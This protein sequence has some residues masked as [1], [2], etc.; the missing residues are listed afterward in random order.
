MQ[1][2]TNLVII[3]G[4][5]GA[6][7]D[8]IIE[9]LIKQGLPIE[10]AITTVTRD[11][12]EGES[13]GNPYYFIDDATFTERIA[14]DAFAEW[15]EVYGVKRGLSKEELERL[16]KQKDRIGVIKVDWQGVQTIKKIV[17]DVL[18]ILVATE[19]IDDMVERGIKRGKD[20]KEAILSRVDFS[21]EWLTHRDIYDY[22]VMNA[23]GKLDQ[24]I[25][26]TI[27]ILKKEGYLDTQA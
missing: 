1:R 2:S 12:R 19:D 3:S 17:P 9:G 26:N 22:E 6:G 15:A 24:A 23:D 20:T 21:K 16:T 8:S 7:E 25:Q 11:M 18:A 10:R 5:S 13:E 27:D 4:P 14:Q